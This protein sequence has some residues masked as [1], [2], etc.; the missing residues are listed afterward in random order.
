VIKQLNTKFAGKVGA[1][2]NLEDEVVEFKGEELYIQA[3]ENEILH[4][5]RFTFCYFLKIRKTPESANFK[6]EKNEVAE[7]CSTLC[8]TSFAFYLVQKS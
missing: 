5:V 4:M 7:F 3:A 8:R 2:C 6:L 1:S